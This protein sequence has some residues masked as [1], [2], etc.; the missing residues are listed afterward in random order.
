MALLSWLRRS[1]RDAP[2]AERDAPESA[3]SPAPETAQTAETRVLAAPRTPRELGWFTEEQIEACRDLADDAEA[4]SR[5]IA[6]AENCASR[7]EL[8]FRHRLSR[9]VYFRELELP[10][11]PSTAAR[12]LQLSRD[13]EASIEDYAVAI[14]GDP[15]LVSAIVRL[16]N[17]ALFSAVARCETLERAIVRIGVAEV[18]KISMLHTF[19]AKLFRA[20][21]HDARVRGLVDHGIVASFAAQAIAREI[22]A[23][24]PEAY[25]G[26]MFHDVG[27]LVLLRT[28]GEV[29]RKLGWKADEALVDS[30]FEAFHAAV[31]GA[32]CDSW[33]LPPSI[34]QAV[35]EH[36][37]PAAC[38]GSPLGRAVHLANRM[39]HAIADAGDAAS[40]AFWIAEPRLPGPA[41]GP[42]PEKLAELQRAVV[43][44]VEAYRGAAGGADPG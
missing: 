23:P 44:E 17:S 27:K 42:A 2:P 32:L 9:A 24:G 40:E 10:P 34:G 3:P 36:H 16:S 39:A 25:L 1:A 41:A 19:N 11:L 18:E 15:S 22:E 43:E 14:Q 13:P 8:L 35:R 29:E 38:A 20:P 33:D 6:R 5:E 30:C 21:G 26:G 31:G 28:I 37:D 4:L 12:V 7:E